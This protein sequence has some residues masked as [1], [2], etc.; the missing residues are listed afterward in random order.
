MKRDAVLG[1]AA[2]HNAFFIRLF[3]NGH[4]VSQCFGIPC[5]DQSHEEADSIMSLLYVKKLFW[6]SGSALDQTIDGL[7]KL[8]L[9]LD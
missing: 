8:K 3:E 7:H 1:Y 2:E 5:Q 4:A 9:H 6:L